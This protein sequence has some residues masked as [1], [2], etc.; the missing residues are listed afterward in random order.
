MGKPAPKEMSRAYCNINDTYQCYLHN[1]LTAANVKATLAA[2]DE[3][4][5]RRFEMSR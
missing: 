5:K 1:V 2:C 3:N 4:R